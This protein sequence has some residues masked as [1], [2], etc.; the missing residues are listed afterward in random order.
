[1]HV[2]K[3]GRENLKFIAHILSQE[4]TPAD[5]NKKRKKRKKNHIY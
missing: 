4:S 1:M 5:A 2:K 3:K